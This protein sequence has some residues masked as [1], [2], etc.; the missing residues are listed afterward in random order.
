VA[1]KRVPKQKHAAA[2]QLGATV[3]PLAKLIAVENHRFGFEKRLS[4]HPMQL[5]SE[6]LAATDALHI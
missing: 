6:H 4:P 5:F 3:C 1:L 2:A